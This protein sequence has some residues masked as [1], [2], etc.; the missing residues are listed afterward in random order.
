MSNN[1]KVSFIVP[2]YNVEKYIEQCIRSLY[3]QDVPLDEYEVIVVNDCSPDN[4]RDIVLKL[5]EEFPT[6]LLIEHANNKKQAGA[7]NTGV[8]E[9]KGEYIWFIDSDDFLQPN[10][11]R[12]LLREAT[13]NNLDVLHFDYIRVTDDNDIQE[14][15]VNYSTNVID[16][17]KFFFDENEI[18]WKKGVE[19]WR[20]LHKRIFL[21]EN[22]IEF[23][24]NSLFEDVKYS[25]QVFNK[26]TR[27]KHVSLSPYNY[28]LNLNSF[29]NLA[30]SGIYLFESVNLAIRCL[31]L[32]EEQTLDKR[33]T[34]I[35]KDFARYHLFEAKK[36]FL[37]LK[38]NEQKIFDNKIRLVAMDKMNFVLKWNEVIFFKF[39]LY[40]RLFSVLYKFRKYLIKNFK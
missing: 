13:E 31:Q 22:K 23:E 27:C 9:A 2:F 14:Y 37:K 21:I 33:Y 30:P 8:K 28:R 12:G 38:Y 32:L 36:I 24:E 25:I 19:V 7:R 16:G 18:W 35:L 17:N 29:F 1:I 4:S 5:K 39:S 11:L 3:N 6:L 40:R 26:T 10:V 34:L 15:P 20:R